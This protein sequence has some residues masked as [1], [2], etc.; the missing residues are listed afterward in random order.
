VRRGA[1]AAELGIEHL[2]VLTAGPWTADA[3]A[4][5][6]AAIPTLRQVGAEVSGPTHGGTG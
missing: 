4:T 3:L 1:A 5:L 2:V 6:A